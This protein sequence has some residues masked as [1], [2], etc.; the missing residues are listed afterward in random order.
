MSQKNEKTAFFAPD[1]IFRAVSL[2]LFA[3]LLLS[4]AS[5]ETEVLHLQFLFIK[6]EIPDSANVS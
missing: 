2:H 3:I 1:P 5:F 6:I 4:P